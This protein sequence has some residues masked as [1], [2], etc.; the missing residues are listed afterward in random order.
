MEAPFDT[1]TWDGVTGAIFAGFGSSEIVWI[2][3]CYLCVLAA[4]ILGWRHEK[5][6][7]DA[8]RSGK[9]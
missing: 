8:A 7:Y 4:M 1:G 3:L 2:G 6:A 9:H 5:H